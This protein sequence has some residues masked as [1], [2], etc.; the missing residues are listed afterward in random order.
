MHD[1][2]LENKLRTR[3]DDD[4]S[5]SREVLEQDPGHQ[6]ETESLLELA[7]RTEQRVSVRYESGPAPPSAFFRGISRLTS[8]VL[9]QQRDLRETAIKHGP[10][11]E[12][13]D[14]DSC[15]YCHKPMEAEDEKD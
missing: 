2:C 13:I 1:S 5:A 7:L 14:S 8:A 6:S 4:E 9:R 10:E 3:P 15:V 12:V 11:I